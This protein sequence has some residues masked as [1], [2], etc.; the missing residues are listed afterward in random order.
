MVTSVADSIQHSLR[1]MGVGCR[2]VKKK[3][4]A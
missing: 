2:K 4:Y 1:K 3:F